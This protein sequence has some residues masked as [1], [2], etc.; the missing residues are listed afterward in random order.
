MMNFLSDVG[1]PGRNGFFVTLTKYKH[2]L[3]QTN[4]K[5]RKTQ[6][7]NSKTKIFYEK[8]SKKR[9]TYINFKKS[10]DKIK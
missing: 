9:H 5:E 1:R 10:C 7:P 3:K 4:Q 8:Y 6:K 2:Y